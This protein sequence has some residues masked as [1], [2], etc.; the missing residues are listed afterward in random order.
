VGAGVTLDEVYEAPHYWGAR[1]TR[2]KVNRVDI[3]F[4]ALT[5]P[6]IRRS[7]PD[8]P[9]FERV[10]WDTQ[11]SGNRARRSRVLEQELRRRLM[12]RE[13]GNRNSGVST[14][15]TAGASCESSARRRDMG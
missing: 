2:R 3:R 6:I 15:S 8:E 10:G 4:D 5:V 1:S 11:M 12:A 9:P 13:P 7:A 14:V